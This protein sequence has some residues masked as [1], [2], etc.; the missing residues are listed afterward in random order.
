MGIF[1][2]KQKATQEQP[3]GVY[4]H[5]GTAVGKGARQPWQAPGRPVALDSGPLGMTRTE[6]V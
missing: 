6:P 5:V 1:R 4:A 2:R 3:L